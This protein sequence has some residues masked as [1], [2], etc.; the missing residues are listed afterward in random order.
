MKLAKTTL[1]TLLLPLVT[2]GFNTSALAASCSPNIEVNSSTPTVN[3]SI[4]DLSGT[5]TVVIVTPGSGTVLSATT[6]LSTPWVNATNSGQARFESPTQENVP[7]TINM[8][9]QLSG[10]N[11]GSSFGLD[12]L[13]LDQVTGD[14]IP[15]CGTLVSY[16]ND[17][18]PPPPTGGGTQIFNDESLEQFTT[19]VVNVLSANLITILLVMAFLLGLTIIFTMINRQGVPSIN[20][21][22]GSDDYFRRM[23]EGNARADSA[24]FGK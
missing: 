20:K 12:W 9:I 10:I 8:T 13:I 3:L 24:R 6:N 21:D 2:I 16:P 1:A 5:A 14:P 18:P 23:R 11:Q 7:T 17:P 4:T 22:Y 19:P 15:A